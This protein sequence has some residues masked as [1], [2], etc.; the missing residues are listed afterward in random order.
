MIKGNKYCEEVE[1]N[2]EICSDKNKER[3]ERAKANKIIKK[4]RNDKGF[5]EREG[6]AHNLK[7]STVKARLE[8]IKLKE[9]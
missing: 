4:K 7:L 9:M 8:E 1:E 6:N 2:A 5:N 3:G